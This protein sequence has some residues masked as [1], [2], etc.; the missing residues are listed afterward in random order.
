[1]TGIFDQ[2]LFSASI[3]GPICLILLLGI[4]LKRAGSINDNFI[5]IASKL[6]FQIT[7]PA[8]LF[9]SIVSSE[10]DFSSSAPLITYGVLSNI[11]FFI[12]SI[13]ITKWLLPSSRDH[14]V[15]I[16][17]GFRANTGII[18]LA[19]VAN[20]YG[21]S[22][23]AIAALYVAA[24]TFL[25]NIQAVIL[26]TPR[27]N[28]SGKQAIKIMFRTI[29]R[30]PLII[31]IVLGMVVYLLAI[32]VPDMLLNTGQYLSRM[33]LPLA[34]LCTGGSLDLRALRHDKA[35]AWFSTILKLVLAPLLLTTVAVLVGFRGLELG[36]IF[37]MNASP[38]AAASYV[39]ARAM[40]GNAQLA[41]NIIAL[42]TVMSLFSCT[43]G[44][45]ILSWFGLM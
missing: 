8:M 6:V 34:L 30:N 28:M 25:Y 42:T 38:T 33:T 21:E 5:E 41:A 43:I 20:A 36:V 44:I 9:I 17:G 23:V 26:L 14:G 1:M 19:Y 35:P 4:L 45:V 39:M 2:F 12:F 3:T 18:S 24:M 11:G 29:T 16:Q 7:L 32:P 31:S 40:G 13:M 22:G 27:G 15:V 37:L 10:H